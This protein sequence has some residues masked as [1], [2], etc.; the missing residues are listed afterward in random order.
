MPYPPSQP[1]PIIRTLPPEEKILFNTPVLYPVSD[2][3]SATKVVHQDSNLTSVP[4]SVDSPVSPVQ[5][6]AGSEL[7]TPPVDSLLASAALLGAT[8]LSVSPLYP[9]DSVTTATSPNSS[10][11]GELTSLRAEPASNVRQVLKGFGNSLV[12]SGLTSPAIVSLPATSRAFNLRS[13]VVQRPPVSPNNPTDAVGEPLELKADRQEYNEERQIFTAVGNVT[14]RFRGAV[15]KA[16]QLQVNLKDQVAVAQGDITLTRGAQVLQGE[17]LE[18]RLAQN[19]GSFLR[20]SGTINL[21]TAAA[22][23]SPGP[24]TEASV[25]AQAFTDRLQNNQPQAKETESIQ[26]L[27][28]RAERIEFNAKGWQAR[29]IRIT[30]D[31][32]SPP[33]L[34]VRADRA[35]LTQVSPLEDKVT[36]TRPR[37]VFD[38]NLSLPIL[39]S[40]TTI[41]RQERD[42]TDPLLP[43]VGF[44]ENERGGVFLEQNFDLLPTD[45]P[46]S[47]RV[48]PQFFLGSVFED[49]FN[50]VDPDL[51]GLNVRLRSDLSP[52]SLLTGFT[53]FTSLDPSQIADNVR[54]R[55][56]LRQAVGSHTLTLETAYRDRLFNGSLGEQTVR[57]SLGAVLASP[58]TVLGNTGINLN[59]QVGTQYIT[60]NRASSAD[61]AS[62]G[63]FQASA[64]LSRAFYL[65]Q[66][67]ALPATATDGLRY[68]PSPVVPYLQLLTGVTGILNA[69]TN[70]DTQQTL[71]G[72]IGLQGQLG[73]F[74]R[75]F[76][77]YTGFNVSYSQVG[78]KGL[79]PFLFDRVTDFKIL[80]AGILQQVYGPVRVGFQTSLNLDTGEQ[81]DTDLIL[82]YSRRTYSLTFRYSPS[83]ELAS[84][85]F[86]LS[87]FNWSSEPESLEPEIRSIRGGIQRTNE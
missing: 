4:E 39:K 13:L 19:Q 60:A 45:A 75:R 9:P 18:Y 67:K 40:Q 49:N 54:A 47:L 61:S 85:D 42:P 34:E 46:T 43:R 21:P 83:R 73:R 41:D 87:G 53:S 37:L 24:A 70:D 51:F 77:D 14:L 2:S 48:S 28:F 32:F 26:Q 52:Q 68:T 7:I 31:P 15:L 58:P 76:L 23:F 69:Y 17:R 3:A 84:I 12:S 8:S 82:D 22:D 30:N 10:S 38:Q 16:D 59:Y 6:A 44:D 79:S 56:S 1:P 50:G 35:E 33:E 72:T 36:T 27:R 81:F 62:L 78:Q 55:L 74:S 11:P 20:V 57:S 66:G 29:D 86:R 71:I 25:D 65:W 80:S 64:G 5:T 63:R